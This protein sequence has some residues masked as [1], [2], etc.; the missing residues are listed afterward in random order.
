MN[1]HDSK[2]TLFMQGQWQEQNSAAETLKRTKEMQQREHL[3][4]LRASRK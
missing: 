4:S 2:I 1:Y 3:K